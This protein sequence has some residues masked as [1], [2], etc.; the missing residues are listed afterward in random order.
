ML[1]LARALGRDA[2]VLLADE[3]SLGLAPLV[4]KRLLAAVRA[5][6]DERAS[7]SCSWSSTC[8]RRSPSPTTC[9]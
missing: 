7:A 5:A 8:G 2:A 4:V 1:S 6:A 3:L 9:T